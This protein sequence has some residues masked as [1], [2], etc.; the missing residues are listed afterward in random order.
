FPTQV[1]LF[2]VNEK[3]SETRAADERIAG[4][5]QGD[6]AER[7]ASERVADGAT[8]SD[9]GGK[10]AR[11][12]LASFDSD[13]VPDCALR[14]HHNLDRFPSV[15]VPVDSRPV[16]GGALSR[17]HPP[18]SDGRFDAG[19]AVDYAR[20]FGRPAPAKDDGRG[21][22]AHDALDSLERARGST[23]LLACRQPCRLRSTGFDKPND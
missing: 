10:S 18:A 3:G 4:K 17:S 13:A 21:H 14:R 8:A 16:G 7:S 2:E 19:L 9:E 6:E 23:R 12:V 11:R 22:A 5:N 15:V 20:T 1:A